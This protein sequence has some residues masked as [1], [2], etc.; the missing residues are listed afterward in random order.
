MNLRSL[1]IIAA[2]IVTMTIAASDKF[3]ALEQQQISIETPG[4]FEQ[5][6]AFTVD[7]AGISSK[8]YC[9]P[10]PVGKA[11]QTKDNELTIS[12]TKGDAVKSMFDGTVRLSRYTINRGNVIVVRHDNGLETVYCHNAENLVKVGDKVE[13]GQTIAIVG[14]DETAAFGKKAKK[15]KGLLTFYI[16]VNGGKVNPG[17]IL[18]IRSHKLLKNTIMCKKNGNYVD[19]SVI[20]GAGRKGGAPSGEPVT[21]FSD[22]NKFEINLATMS[23]DEWCYPLPDAKVI[24]AYGR[25]D[26]RRHTGV[27]IKTKANDEIYA[28][29]E[30]EVVQSGPFSG[31]GNMIRIR[32]ANGLET[33]YSHNSKNLVKVG[34]YVKAG[35]VIGLVGR[36]G[37]AT[38]PHLHFECRINGNPFDPAKIFDH[39]NHSIKM[40]LVTFT[41]K[42]SNISIKS[43]KNYMAKGR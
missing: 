35:Q 30:G 38:T 1:F 41:K 15:G 10:L 29:F 16:M 9:F 32:H 27:D 4:L 36:T 5:S 43:E 3:T 14:L 20:R 12:T 28:A 2:L 26:G 33:L 17:T 24:S 31:Y 23:P 8:D 22:G 37:R 21:P 7:F 13:A 39:Q 40:E 11:K 18:S 34:D 6:D 25:R 19:L 42:G